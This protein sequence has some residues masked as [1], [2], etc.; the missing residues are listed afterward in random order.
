MQSRATVSLRSRES[1]SCIGA[2]FMHASRHSQRVFLNY[3]FEFCTQTETILSACS[4]IIMTHKTTLMQQRQ[5]VVKSTYL[6][7]YFYDYST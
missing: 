3:K 6:Q 2:F 7:V 4:A 5:D 1:D